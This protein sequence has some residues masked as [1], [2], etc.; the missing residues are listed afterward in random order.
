MHARMGARPWLAH[1]QYEYAAML[2]KRR[3]PGDAQRAWEL[4]EQAVATFGDLEM[5]YWADKARALLA[6]LIRVKRKSWHECRSLS[7]AA[8]KYLADDLALW[9][10]HR[11]QG[12]AGPG[13]HV[14]AGD[15][16]L[17]GGQPQRL[18]AE[19]AARGLEVVERLD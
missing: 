9:R 17:P 10:R 2:L 6:C 19:G 3:T 8:Q 11:V 12:L 15:V 18:E 1:T 14:E 4:L 16:H 5:E 7:G 13:V